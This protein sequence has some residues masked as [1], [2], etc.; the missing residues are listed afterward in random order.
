[1][2]FLMIIGFH[3]LVSRLQTEGKRRKRKK[4][5]KE[6]ERKRGKGRESERAEIVRMGFEEKN[7]GRIEVKEKVL[8]KRENVLMERE[9][10]F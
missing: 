1:M 6:K 4:R 2:L 10:K 9:R 3:H 5:K 7:N 8:T